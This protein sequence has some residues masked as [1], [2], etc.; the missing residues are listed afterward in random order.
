MSLLKKKRP[1]KVV[2]SICIYPETM[3]RLDALT[4][5]LGRVFDKD[6]A[7]QPSRSA[8]VESMIT[9]VANLCE[10]DAKWIRRLAEAE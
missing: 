3:E 5:Q 1:E 4:E 10:K 8:V 7:K 9:L 6:L 2:T